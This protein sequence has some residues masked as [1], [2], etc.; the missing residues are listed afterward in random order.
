MASYS[1][2]LAPC[3]DA[4]VLRKIL[5]RNIL[6]NDVNFSG[7]HARQYENL[8]FI[9]LTAMNQVEVVVTKFVISWP[10]TIQLNS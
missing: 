7:F 9:C 10:M 2:N 8:T 6:S 5:C 1:E 4:A 3:A